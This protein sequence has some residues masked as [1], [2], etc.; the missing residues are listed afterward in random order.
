VLRRGGH[1]G[2][3]HGYHDASYGDAFADV[4]D[5][6]Y[7]GAPELGDTATIVRTLA[8]L[9]APGARV[10]ELG[11]GTGRLAIPLAAALADHDGSEVHGLDASAPMLDR[12]AAKPGAT[13]VRHH[14]GDMV[15]G[16]P[17]GPFTLVFAAYNTFFNL[18]SGQRQQ[19]CFRA[20]ASR[21]T[22]GGRFVVEA[23]VPAEEAVAAREVAVKSVT[24]DRVVLSVSITDPTTQVA[25]GQYVEFTEAG[26]V[27][28]RPWSVRWCTPAQ[29]D[30][31]AAAA[32]LRLEHRWEDF[33][34]TPFGHDSV[35]QVAVFLNGV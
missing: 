6:W 17:D 10:L 13:A 29:L 11:V 12:L 15:D 5:E 18:L 23:F 25:E 32:G 9:A 8:E 19:E 35:R 26:G 3:V 30:E 1:H 22:P 24:A 14:L 16:L 31:M 21:L 2:A 4:Y 34:R 7:D 33:A 28:L 20:V 27:R